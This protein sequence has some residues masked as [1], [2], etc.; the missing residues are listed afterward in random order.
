ML[1]I[2][3]WSRQ[4]W[5]LLAGLLGALLHCLPAQAVPAMPESAPVQLDA[6]QFELD[7]RHTGHRYRIYLSVPDVPPPAGGYPVLYALDGDF[8]FPVFHLLNPRD[9]SQLARLAQHGPAVPD[10]GVVV[11]IGYGRPY[12]ATMDLR[13]ADYTI[14]A[15]KGCDLRSPLHGGAAL[16][17]R[18]IEEELKPEIARRLPVNTRRQSLFG[19]SYGGLFTLYQLL[20]QP[21]SFQQYFA[22]SPSIWFDS[23]ALLN[24]RPAALPAGADPR[25][26]LLWVGA[27]EQ[28]VDLRSSRARQARLQQSRM[29]D[30]VADFARWQMARPDVLIEQRVIPGHDHGHMHLYAIDRALD[31][32]FLP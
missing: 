3:S 26:L 28:A 23:R 21:A 31:I 18:F 5:P 17:S 29:V 30:N 16:F 9:A 8:S 27:D 4:S 15:C 13:A 6:S 14:T 32:A 25:L 1:T 12:G 24:M 11:G 22:I 7:S 2:S 20:H 19:H 10:A